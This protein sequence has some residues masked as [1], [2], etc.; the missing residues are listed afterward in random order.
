MADFINTTTFLVMTGLV[1]LLASFVTIYRFLS[2]WRR[3]SRDSAKIVK[4]LRWSLS[5]TGY[6]FRSPEAI[7]SATKIPDSRVS[8]LA[9]QHKKLRRN[10]RKRQ[11]WQLE[12]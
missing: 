7:A 4:F 9:G 1:G 11:T 6:R 5:A 3:D 12:E 2:G 10:R 8:M